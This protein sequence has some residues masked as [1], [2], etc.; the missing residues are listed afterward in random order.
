MGRQVPQLGFWAGYHPVLKPFQDLSRHE[1]TT[2]TGRSHRLSPQPTPPFHLTDQFPWGLDLFHRTRCTSPLKYIHRQ[3]R[4]AAHSWSII[5]ACHQY[6]GEQWLIVFESS[7]TEVGNRRLYP[8]SHKNSFSCMN[9]AKDKVEF[10]GTYKGAD[11]SLQPDFFRP[12][13]HM[14]TIEDRPG[15]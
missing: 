4:K 14:R 6:V 9:V 2:T 1:H 15:P 5:R 12:H 11:C 7:V 10:E 3:S 13:V 8:E